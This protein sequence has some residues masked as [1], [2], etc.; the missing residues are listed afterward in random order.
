MKEGPEV[1]VP[2]YDLAG[3]VCSPRGLRSDQGDLGMN[4][5]NT[6]AEQTLW[7][8]GYC[9]KQ[10]C[11]D[12]AC[13]AAFIGKEKAEIQKCTACY[14]LRNLDPH[15]ESMPS[16]DEDDE[17]AAR[18]RKKRRWDRR[19]FWMRCVEYI[20]GREKGDYT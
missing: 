10:C 2:R 3:G 11:H 15:F 5:Y 9:G 13:M 4:V 7:E 20:R 17:E 14:S 6:Y 19:C 18:R 16:D 12:A 8:M 1:Y